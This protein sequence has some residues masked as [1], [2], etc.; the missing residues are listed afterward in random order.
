MRARFCLALAFALTICPA[1][2]QAPSALPP[3]AGA[4]EVRLMTKVGPQT[5]AWIRQEAQRQRGS[6]NLSDATAVQAVRNNPAL[7]RLPD[8]DV[9]A[10]A[11]LV[12]MEA[13]RSAQE[14]LKTIMEGV[15]QINSSKDA[16]R[17][18]NA[19]SRVATAGLRN[20]T[21]TEVAQPRV[22]QNVARVAIQPVPVPKPEFDTRLAVA[23]NNLDSLNEMGD[24]ESLRLQMAMDRMSK[25]MSMLSN[26]LKK[27]SDTGSTI[28]Q[29]LK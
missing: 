18:T 2:A 4:T 15:K 25:F 20:G 16:L 28:T 13:S 6:S 8:G 3:A 24:M 19:K 5:R 26:L 23:R 29:N 11:F 1:V 17:Q 7:G 27:V 21:Q 12:M 14:D 22:A 9:E 10:L